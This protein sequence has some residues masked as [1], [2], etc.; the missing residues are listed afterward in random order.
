MTEL[1][2]AARM[3]LEA[4]EMWC[5]MTATYLNT[6]D[7]AITALRRAL[8]QPAQQEPVAWRD[9]VEQ[10]LLTWRQS[11][12]NKSGDQ[13]ALED[14]MDKRSL[15]DLIDFVCSEY[16]RPQA[17]EP[18]QPAQQEPVARVE[19]TWASENGHEIPGKTELYAEFFNEPP[20][21]GTLLYT[22]PQAREPLTDEQIQEVVKKAVRERKLSWLGFTKD[23]QGEYTIP[24]LSPS[25]YQMARAIEAAHGIKGDA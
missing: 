15:D 7:D 8:E 11:F 1:E 22:R 5:P 10:R 12:V 13:L 3:A 4:L 24:V 17:R 16:T 6:R 14:F 20:P 19:E 21:K 2:K 23:D 9:H 25:D 18:E